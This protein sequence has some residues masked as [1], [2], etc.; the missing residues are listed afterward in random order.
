MIREIEKV[1]TRRAVVDWI[2]G[3]LESKLPIS[4]CYHNVSHT[5]DVMS[6]AFRMASYDGIPDSE[7]ELLM[8]AGAFHDSGFLISPLDHEI[9]GAQM[10]IDAMTA[11]GTFSASEIDTVQQLIKDT[12]TVEMKGEITQVLTIELSGYL[13]DADL[14]NLGR[15]DFW[16]KWEQVR[17]ENNLDCNLFLIKTGQRLAGHRW[18]TNAARQFFTE[19][20]SVNYAELLGRLPG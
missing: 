4:L 20:F 7:I 8:I 6:E 18:R 9:R 3:E 14:A 1:L 15:V 11:D 19:Q 5:R 16:D 17:S 2:L 12:A 13:I 10:A